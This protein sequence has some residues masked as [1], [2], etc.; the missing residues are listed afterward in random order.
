MK[1]PARV[2]IGAIDLPEL[3]R[4]HPD[5]QR[6]VIQ[7]CEGKEAEP[8]A[9]QELQAVLS[10][11]GVNLGDLLARVAS[12]QIAPGKYRK[13]RAAEQRRTEAACFKKTHRLL[14]EQLK[15]A[16]EPTPAT[17]AEAITA[18]SYGLTVEAM[19]K[20]ISRSKQNRRRD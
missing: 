18:E 17:T 15:A 5:L 11:F 9:V 16:K 13:D 4:L 6:A 8:T 19:R 7:I 2:V 3:S 1:P 10:F 20:R 12:Q 14:A